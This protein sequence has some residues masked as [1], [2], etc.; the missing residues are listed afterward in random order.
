MPLPR[1]QEFCLSA[2]TGCGD[3]GSNAAASAGDLLVTC[4]GAP[5]PKLRRSAASEDEMRVGVDKSGQD[6]ATFKIDRFCRWIS[7]YEDSLIDGERTAVDEREFLQ[8]WTHP[9]PS[10][11]GESRDSGVYEGDQAS[12]SLFDAI[13]SARCSSVRSP[14][15]TA[16]KVSTASSCLAV[17]ESPLSLRNAYIAKNAVR[18]FPSTNGRFLTIP[19][20]YA[21]ASRGSSPPS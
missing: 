17:K 13:Q 3:T 2:C 4:T 1:S 16:R 14:V 7:L 21:A 10:W 20:A 18:S 6:E 15:A 12:T 8:L 11:P 5:Q 9:R 19:K